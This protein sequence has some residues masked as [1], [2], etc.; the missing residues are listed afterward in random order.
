MWLWLFVGYAVFIAFLIA[1]A[2]FVALF[3]GDRERR[4]A[5]YR[6]LKLVWVTVT[7]GSGLVVF[8]T[9]L[10]ESGVLPA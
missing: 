4:S 5:G 1:A 6:V 7:S 9:K 8:A 10:H 2:C 3:G